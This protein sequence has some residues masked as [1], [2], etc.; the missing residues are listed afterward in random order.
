MTTQASHH[1]HDLHN[2][3]YPDPPSTEHDD[4][5]SYAAY[6]ERTGLDT[7][8]NTY[9]GT[10]YEYAVAA[11]LR[12][13]GFDLR[14]VGGRADRGI[15]LLGTWTLPSPT[16][17]P[18]S[19]ISSSS[20]PPPPLRILLQCKASASRSTAVGPQYIRE[21]EG[22]FAG[23]PAGWRRRLSASGRV[24]APGSE[25]G[26]GSGVLGLLVAQRPATKGIR[27]ALGR[28]RWPMG[29]VA[30]AADGRLQQ[31]LWNR[32]AEDEGLEGLGVGV[33]YFEVVQCGGGGGRGKQQ[34]P[35]LDQELVLTWR[36][37]PVV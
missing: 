28:S 31:M 34:Q 23:A 1:N 7:A 17:S 22:A 16:P 18:S 10:Q 37:K 20:S 8:S 3:R 11:A 35:P 29:Y 4:Q 36:G 9:V 21:L 15:D 14:R 26:P 32:A 33:R 2:L 19:P 13:L 27:D 24:V 6:A 12:R 25:S 5:A 30:C